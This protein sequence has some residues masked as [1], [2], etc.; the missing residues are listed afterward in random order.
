VAGPGG[1][2]VDYHVGVTSWGS[3]CA[4]ASF[5]GVYSR[6]A[7][8]INF[9]RKTICVD[10]KSNHPFCETKTFNCNSNQEKLVI[11]VVPDSFPD[12]ISKFLSLYF[13]API[14][15]PSIKNS[16][17]ITKGKNLSRKKFSLQICDRG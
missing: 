1:K 9:I 14:L 2:R 8:G 10:G 17:M 4:S 7:F 12:D 11:K 16:N 13:L 3:G 6:T 5:P 15:G